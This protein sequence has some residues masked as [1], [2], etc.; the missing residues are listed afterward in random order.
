[1]MNKKGFTL[2]ELLAVIAIIAIVSLIAV[3][4]MI[5]IS[6]D[7][8]KE[9]MLNDAKKLISLARMKV[10]TDYDIRNFISDKCSATQCD[11]TISFL[12]NSKDINEDPDGGTYGA[13]SYVRYYK[14]GSTNTFCVYLVG[15]KRFLS[16]QTSGTITA[17]CVPENRLNEKAIVKTS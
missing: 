1:M 14:S 17:D 11:F 16:T 8:R 9:Q 7:V 15:S 5:G 2:I 3:P 13:S 12:D 4:N 10:N 6:D